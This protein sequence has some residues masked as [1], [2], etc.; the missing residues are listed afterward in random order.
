[1]SVKSDH[2]ATLQYL[3]DKLN[4]QE[5][6]IGTLKFQ[7]AAL[8]TNKIF[9]ITEAR[10]EEIYKVLLSYWFEYKSGEPANVLMKGARD[11]VFY[12]FYYRKQT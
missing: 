3:K 6:E 7:L 9:H 1:M 12:A 4:N 8:E 11:F 10:I 5:I 2:E